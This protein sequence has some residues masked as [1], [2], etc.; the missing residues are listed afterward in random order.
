MVE[1]EK[2]SVA[3]EKPSF[4]FGSPLTE[5][6]KQTI[7]EILRKDFVWDSNYCSYQMKS[8][9][10][11]HGRNVSR[12]TS[13]VGEMRYFRE[14]NKCFEWRLEEEARLKE[15][16]LAFAESGVLDAITLAF[17]VSWNRKDDFAVVRKIVRKYMDNEY[18][19]Y[20][21]RNKEVKELD[22]IKSRLLALKVGL[23]K[24]AK[25]EVNVVAGGEVHKI[26][27]ARLKELCANVKDRKMIAKIV[28]EEDLS[29]SIEE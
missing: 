4:V 5:E 7:L 11:E 3:Q 15:T 19:Y 23:K 18:D 29:N 2:E 12:A 25:K 1:N 6:E 20:R 13:A 26:S 22:A 8:F 24:Y 9:I 21:D 14:T 17:A 28:I 16:A 27:E 10:W